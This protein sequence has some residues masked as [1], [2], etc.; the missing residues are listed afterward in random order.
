M[1]R[2]NIWERN[3]PAALPLRVG[4][5]AEFNKRQVEDCLLKSSCPTV[6]MSW[7]LRSFIQREVISIKREG[8]VITICNTELCIIIIIVFTI[9]VMIII[10]DNMRMFLI[11]SWRQQRFPG[12]HQA[13][14]EAC[15]R[16]YN[17]SEQVSKRLR[18]RRNGQ[19]LERK[20]NTSWWVL[21]NVASGWGHQ[22]LSQR[23]S[24]KGVV[25]W[26]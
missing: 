3:Q 20:L 26:S 19:K 23:E 8:K 16:A 5:E 1:K 25:L 24:G 13:G 7:A 10:R 12:S 11:N 15:A 6:L 9:M 14:H 21:E 17:V 22:T 2:S 4:G 18:R